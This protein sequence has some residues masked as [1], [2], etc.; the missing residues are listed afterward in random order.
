[1]KVKTVNKNMIL[2]RYL[3][4][5]EQK[6]GSFFVPGKFNNAN[7]NMKTTVGQRLAVAEVIQIGSALD[8]ENE[9]KVGDKV[10]VPLIAQSEFKTNKEGEI[11]SDMTA[12]V[13][14]NEYDVYACIL[15]QDIEGI[16][17]D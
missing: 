6:V 7:P 14:D 17:E 5:P 3:R 16:V 4:E 1:M 2:V 13:L 10:I 9:F 8:K 11:L 15:Y 12:S